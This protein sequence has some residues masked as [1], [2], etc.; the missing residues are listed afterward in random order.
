MRVKKVYYN[1]NFKLRLFNYLVLQQ[2][3][4]IHKINQFKKLFSLKLT[5]YHLHLSLTSSKNLNLQEFYL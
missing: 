3:K 1:K 4:F 2:E 5:Y